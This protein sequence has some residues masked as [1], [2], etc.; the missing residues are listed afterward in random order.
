MGSRNWIYRGPFVT[1]FDV[2]F[3]C[4]KWTIGAA[5]SGAT[6]LSR[7][8]A[9]HSKTDAC[10]TVWLFEN[11]SGTAARWIP[12]LS[13]RQTIRPFITLSISKMLKSD[14][15]VTARVHRSALCI[16]VWTPGCDGISDRSRRRCQSKRHRKHIECIARVKRL[17]GVGCRWDSP[18]YTSLLFME[19]RRLCDCF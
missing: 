2:T 15:D 8:A 9:H 10:D 3:A 5:T 1:Q 11:D 16:S 17:N 18:H 7:V 13:R 12:T 4:E 14:D 19:R 6:C